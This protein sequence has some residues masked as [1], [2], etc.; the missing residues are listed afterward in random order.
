MKGSQRVIRGIILGIAALLAGV[1]VVLPPLFL[2]SGA[3]A[4]VAAQPTPVV[5]DPCGGAVVWGNGGYQ[6]DGPPAADGSFQ[7]CT[8]V[9]VLGIGGWNCFTVYPPPP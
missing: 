5:Q 7:R 8:G 3:I 4:T 1:F 2:V 6:C 9:W